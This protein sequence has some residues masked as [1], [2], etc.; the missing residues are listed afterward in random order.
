[1]YSGIH[2]TQCKLYISVVVPVMPPH[3]DNIQARQPVC[4]Q[5]SF[6]FFPNLGYIRLILVFALA[7]DVNFS[8]FPVLLVTGSK[9]AARSA[10]LQS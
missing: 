1:M 7:D 6:G 3:I 8:I 2:T 9:F 4:L 10:L 5:C